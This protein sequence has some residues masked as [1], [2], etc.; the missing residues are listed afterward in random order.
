MAGPIEQ[1]GGMANRAMNQ[2]PQSYKQAV[3]GRATH[4]TVGAL[5]RLLTMRRSY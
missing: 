5:S 2:L 3:G 4:P 1:P